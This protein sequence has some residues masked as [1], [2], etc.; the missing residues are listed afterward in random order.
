MAYRKTDRSFVKQFLLTSVTTA[1]GSLVIGLAPGLRAQSAPKLKFEVASIRPA[2][3]PRSVIESGMMPHRGT[4]IDGARV[5]IG[6]A[7]L[8]QLVPVVMLDVLSDRPRNRS[9]HETNDKNDS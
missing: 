3:D 6:S 4:K 8:L 1:I 9:P 7:T 2:T 5:D